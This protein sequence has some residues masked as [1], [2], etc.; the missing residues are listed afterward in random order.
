MLILCTGSCK[1]KNM[2]H[3]FHKSSRHGSN[4]SAGFVVPGQGFFR[5]WWVEVKKIQLQAVQDRVCFP[6]HFTSLFFLTFQQRDILVR[7]SILP[8]FKSFESLLSSHL[9]LANPL[10]ADHRDWPH[11]ENTIMSPWLVWVPDLLFLLTLTTASCHLRF[12]LSL[13]CFP[14]FPFTVYEDLHCLIL[15]PLHTAWI[16]MQVPWDEIT[17]TLQADTLLLI[18][19]VQREDHS[20]ILEIETN[21]CTC[22]FIQTKCELQWKSDHSVG[23]WLAYS[24]SAGHS[25]V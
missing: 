1:C 10:K 17:L 11:Q 23:A 18:C 16:L 4:S 15:S 2:Y 24:R 13:F 7:V 6:S 21:M 25:P 22:C 19:D 9:T 8:A 3:K 20:W 14:P 12:H 5:N